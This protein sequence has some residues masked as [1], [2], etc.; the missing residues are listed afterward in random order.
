MAPNTFIDWIGDNNHPLREVET[1]SFRAMI[2]A[3]NPDA[4]ADLWANHQSVRNYIIA[5]FENYYPAVIDFIAASPTKIH[6]TF[7]GWTNKGRKRS[8]T[9]IYIHHLD[10][11]GQ[12][13]EYLLALP[14]QIGKHTGINLAAVIDEVLCNF[15]ITKEKLGYFTIDNAHNN[16][17]CIEELGQAYDFKAEQRR[18]RCAAHIINLVA[19]DV[20]FGKSRESFENEDYIPVSNCFIPP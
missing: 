9:G 1:A 14:R 15:G 7:D 12:I 2:R 6:V 5:D 8:F 18:C 11:N 16:D 20:I 10:N 4:E 19:Q 3:A 17:T 13:R